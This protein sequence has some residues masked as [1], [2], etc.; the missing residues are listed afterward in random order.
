MA[1]TGVWIQ[2]FWIQNWDLFHTTSH[3]SVWLQTHKH[4]H[5]D[6]FFYNF[7]INIPVTRL[8][9]LK[10]H[11]GVPKVSLC[12][13]YRTHRLKCVVGKA[14]EDVTSERVPV[15]LL[16]TRI[17]EALKDWKDW[18]GFR[19]FLNLTQVPLQMLVI[20]FLTFWAALLPSWFS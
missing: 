8:Q 20:S 14:L 10:C 18:V 2:D 12:W 13:L 17:W 9:R 6:M 4:T 3:M 11:C 19:I 16:H 15:S 1:R 7:R 5:T